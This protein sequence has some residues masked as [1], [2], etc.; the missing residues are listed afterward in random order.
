MI[1]TYVKPWYGWQLTDS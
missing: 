1:R